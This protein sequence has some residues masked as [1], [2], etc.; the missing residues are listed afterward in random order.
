VRAKLADVTDDRTEAALPKNAESTE[1]IT[2]LERDF[3]GGDTA[4]ALVVYR[5]PDGLTAADR[6]RIAGDTRRARATSR[7][8]D[9]RGRLTL[10][11]DLG[12]PHE[13]EQFSGPGQPDFVT[14]V[15][16]LRR[17]P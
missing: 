6:A 9:R 3:P 1:V 17:S 14:R 10:T 11:V 8:A 16:R 7:R 4:S 13:D 12:P 15:V 2:R 5:R